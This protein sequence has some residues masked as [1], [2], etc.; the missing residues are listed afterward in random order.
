MPTSTK[1]TDSQLLGSHLAFYCYVYAYNHVLHTAIVSLLPCAP[2]STPWGRYPTLLI[3]A[4]VYAALLLF[5]V[6][7]GIAGKPQ[8]AMGI[9][10]AIG[11]LYFL[12]M[13]LS[14]ALGIWLI[15]KNGKPYC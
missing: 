10:Q 8:G 12:M 5:Q 14:V 2:C 3:F 1:Y 13:C 7:M 6:M 11:V 15:V 4:L 9:Y